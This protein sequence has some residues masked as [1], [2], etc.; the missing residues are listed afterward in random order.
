MG[1]LTMAEGYRIDLL[2]PV[3]VLLVLLFSALL[4]LFQRKQKKSLIQYIILI[5][6]CYYLVKLVSV[7]FFPFDISFT[8]EARKS[9]LGTQ[10]HPNF[11]PFRSIIDSIDNRTS[12]VQ[13]G[14]NL[15]LLLPFGFYLP[16]LKRKVLSFK[17]VVLSGGLFSLT[18]EI[19]QGCMN[20]LV[21]YN[22]RIVDIDD[23]ILNTIGCLV[24][25]TVFRILFLFINN[26]L[27]VK[28]QVERT[29]KM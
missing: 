1:G 27:N 25:Y 3:Q 12:W 7:T 22:Y 21:G 26:L 19:L 10:A 20:Y 23:I 9:L 6:F 16:L 14:G 2:F 18:I 29:Y 13:N 4:I 5:S 28:K 17:T 8:E 15:L 11:V 24:G